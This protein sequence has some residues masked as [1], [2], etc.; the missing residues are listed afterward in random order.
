M[1]I[2]EPPDAAWESPD[3]DEVKIPSEPSNLRTLGRE[4]TTRRYIRLGTIL[5][6]RSPPPSQPATPSWPT[7]DSVRVERATFIPALG[8]ISGAPHNS[9]SPTATWSPD[10]DEITRPE[11][12]A[13]RSPFFSD[14][15]RPGAPHQASRIARGACVAAGVLALGALLAVYPLAE[16][17]GG[18]Q[19]RGAASEPAA[20]IAVAL[21]QRAEPAMPA[22]APAA[23]SLAPAAAYAPPTSLTPMTGMAPVT[24]TSSARSGTQATPTLALL[25]LAHRALAS[26]KYELA[27]SYYASIL[28]RDPRDAEAITGL[29]DVARG[30]GDLAGATQRYRQAL[31]IAP[32]FLPA[33][34]GL[35]D[36]HWDAKDRARSVAEYRS[37]VLDSRDVPS[38]VEERAASAAEGAPAHEASP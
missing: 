33:R 18:A 1:I 22:P 38:Y 37:I 11:R 32:R 29:A 34:I 8:G 12:P 28:S 24:I 2:V 21:S 36:A 30:R 7:E 27:A 31:G 14:S 10:A 23:P 15:A 13:G 25:A 19:V 4:E 16:L 9:L 5:S 26:Q 6:F 3:M 35:A 20:P 17:H